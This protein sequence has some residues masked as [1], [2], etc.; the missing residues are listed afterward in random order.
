MRWGSVYGA[1]SCQMRITD[2]DP[3]IDG[4]W[5]AIGDTTRVSNLVTELES[6]KAYWFCVSAIGSAGE[7]A[8]CLPAMGRAA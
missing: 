4:N 6:Y 2:K 1:R 7:G 3:A 8:Q 5:Q